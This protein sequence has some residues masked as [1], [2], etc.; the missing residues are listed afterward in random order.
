MQRRARP[1]RSP[2]RSATREHARAAP[3]TTAQLR[4]ASIESRFIARLT[5]SLCRRR[6]R[7]IA[8]S[9]ADTSSCTLT[10][11]SCP[12]RR[13]EAAERVERPHR[14]VLDHEVGRLRFERVEDLLQVGRRREELHVDVD[15]PKRPSSCGGWFWLVV[16]RPPLPSIAARTSS[17]SSAPARLGAVF[18]R[19]KRR[20]SFSSSPPAPSRY[21]GAC[22]ATRR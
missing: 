21:S 14:H 2:S 18:L 16:M 4:S 20:P 3:A 17:G 7:R 19:K 22:A 15:L 10:S 13:L 5:C 12:A 6:L 8:D 11:G 9:R 1:S